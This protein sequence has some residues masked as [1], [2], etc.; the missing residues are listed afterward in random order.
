MGGKRRKWAFLMLACLLLF[1]RPVRA[2]EGGTGST[3]MTVTVPE[4]PEEEIMAS[5]NAQKLDDVPLPE[6]WRWAEKDGSKKLEPGGSVTG[7]AVFRDS[8]GNVLAEREVTVTAPKRAPQPESGNSS[9]DG[10]AGGAQEENAYGEAAGAGNK[11]ASGAASAASGAISGAAEASA[12]ASGTADADKAASGAAGQSA[13]AGTG[14]ETN[15]V[16]W[17]LALL[18]SAAFIAYA[19]AKRKHNANAPA[20]RRDYG[21]DAEPYRK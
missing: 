15:A 20:A 10:N 4:Q 17:A 13:G 8:D 19:A 7:T 2:Q 11:A 12:A 14:D 1:C 6:G 3:G 5:A 18:A 21:A 16:G 9:P